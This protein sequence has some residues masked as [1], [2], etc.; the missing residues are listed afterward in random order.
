MASE[1]NSPLD[2][3]LLEAVSAAVPN[4]T[5]AEAAAIAVAIGAHVRDGEV[6]AAAGDDETAWT[7]REWPFSGRVEQTQQRTVR[8]RTDAPADAWSAAGRTDRM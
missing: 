4:A 6:A 5:T 1:P 8:V 3:A 2:P 7:G